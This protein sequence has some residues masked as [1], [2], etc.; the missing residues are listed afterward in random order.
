[1]RRLNKNSAAFDVPEDYKE[2]ME[3]L[4]QKSKEG[5]PGVKGY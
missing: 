3:E 5:A 4:I 1:M 2:E